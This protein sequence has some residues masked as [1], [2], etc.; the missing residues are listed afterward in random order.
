MPRQLPHPLHHVGTVRKSAVFKLESGLHH[1]PN[2]PAP[3]S[4]ISQPPELWEINLCYYKPPP[5]PCSVTA[6]VRLLL[7]FR[8]KSE[9][10]CLSLALSGHPDLAPTDPSSH[11]SPL[12]TS[13]SHVKNATVLRTCPA[14]LSLTLIPLQGQ[15]C[16]RHQRYHIFGG[17][18]SFMD[19]PSLSFYTRQRAL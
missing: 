1:P 10:V 15:S 2:Q 13:S 3:P 7:A 16:K 12:S 4:W 18:Q 17:K 11:Q 5:L 14:F 6:A 19:S 8:I 9:R